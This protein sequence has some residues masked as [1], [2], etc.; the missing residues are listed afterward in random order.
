MLDD[1][2]NDLDTD[3]EFSG[4]DVIEQL[5]QLQEDTENNQRR[6]SAARYRRGIEDWAERR[7]MRM[8]V[9]YLDLI[10]ADDPPFAA[11]DDTREFRASP[12]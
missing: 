4:E 9:D 6:S 5:R 2:F 10:E 7:A 8:A 12:Q 11:R 3:V 1:D